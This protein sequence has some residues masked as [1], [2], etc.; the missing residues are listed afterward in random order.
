[1][2]IINRQL[3]KHGGDLAVGAYG[4]VNRIA[5]LFV[6]VVMGVN[7]GMQPIAGYNY[8]AQLN[9]RVLKVLR[10]AIL[11]ASAIMVVG[12]LLVELF[13]HTVASLF[14][15]EEHLVAI[16]VPGLRWVF[17]IYP[18]VG[19]QMVTSAFFQSIGKSEKSIFLAMTRQVLFLIPFLLIFPNLWG[20]TGVWTSMTVSDLISV[21]LSATLLFRE[22]KKLH[23]YGGKLNS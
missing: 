10:R 13:P 20:I 6:M 15:T 21:V 18:L 3:L 19:F 12:F 11:W 2:I 9:D 16:A 7:Q 5:F 4:I 14:T 8:G 1:V 23:H 22:Y 17:A